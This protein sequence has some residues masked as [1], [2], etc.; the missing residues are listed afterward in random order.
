MCRKTK[1]V[2]KVDAEERNI[3]TKLINREEHNNYNNSA[4]LQLKIIVIDEIQK[5]NH[6]QTV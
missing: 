2:E 1:Y 3:N 4:Y 6:R 5:E